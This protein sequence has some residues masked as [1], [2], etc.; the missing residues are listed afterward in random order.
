MGPRLIQIVSNYQY[1]FKSFLTFLKYQDGSCGECQTW[2]IHTC[3]EYHS[4]SGARPS[5]RPTPAS[6]EAT[7]NTRFAQ[8]EPSPSSHTKHSPYTFF[9]L[10]PSMH[11]NV[12]PQAWSVQ[13][14]VY[15]FL[16][17]HEYRWFLKTMSQGQLALQY[18][19]FH[20]ICPSLT[21]VAAGRHDNWQSIRNILLQYIPIRT[22]RPII[23]N[24]HRSSII[25]SWNGMEQK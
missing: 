22:D 6:T 9:Q 1:A 18:H 21:Y 15:H 7:Q 23:F 25:A 8:R 11:C 5:T 14:A 3:Q 13:S 2:T 12:L 19:G 16:A 24:D 10:F 4:Q 20:Y 17:G